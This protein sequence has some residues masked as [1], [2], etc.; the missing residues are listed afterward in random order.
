MWNLLALRDNVKKLKG[1]T[2]RIRCVCITQSKNSICSVA[3]DCQVRF[4]DTSSGE[5]TYIGQH[6]YIPTFCIPNGIRPSNADD[7]DY[8]PSDHVLTCANDAV[9][10]IW[11]TRPD[12]KFDVHAF[13]S[14]EKKHTDA[15][16]YITLTSNLDYLISCSWDYSVRIWKVSDHTLVH[17]LADDEESPIKTGHTGHVTFCVMDPNDQYLV[18]CS[19]DNTLKVWTFFEGLYLKTLE[20]H[21]SCVNHAHLLKLVHFKSFWLKTLPHVLLQMENGLSLRLMIRHYEFGILKQ[22]LV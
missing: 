12:K 3:S 18:S 11:D 15:I 9:I 5:C 21:T 19:N 17:V 22:V 13:G 4:W 7:N 8:D 16:S 10:K 6:R 14:E 1:H 2:N 20:G